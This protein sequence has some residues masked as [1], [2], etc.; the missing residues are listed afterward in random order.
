MMLRRAGTITA[1]GCGLL[2]SGCSMFFHIEPHERKYYQLPEV[3]LDPP[4]EAGACPLNLVIKDSRA[5]SFVFSHKIVFSSS[6]YEQ[7]FYQYASWVESPPIRLPQ[8]LIAAL[9]ESG[10][11]RSVSH[12][13]SAVTGDMQMSSVLLEFYQDTS[14]EPGSVHVKIQA[15]LAGAGG[16]KFIA[17]R[18]FEKEVP[19]ASFDAEGAVQAFS[20]AVKEIFQDMQLWMLQACLRDE[21]GAQH[22]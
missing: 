9:E 21:A 4:E 1:V 3:H 7:G 15:E 5:D 12:I 13:S 14:A 2:L 18:T 22:E 20:R 16:R 19:A 6:P 17:Q 8:I 11:F 10:R